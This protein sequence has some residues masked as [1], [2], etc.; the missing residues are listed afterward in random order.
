MISHKYPFN[1]GGDSLAE[2][3]FKET[4]R[5]AGPA[6]P[7]HLE[8]RRKRVAQFLSTFVTKVNRQERGLKPGSAHTAR[9]ASVFTE[10][11]VFRPPPP[12][13][14]QTDGPDCMAW[15]SDDAKIPDQFRTRRDQPGGLTG[16]AGFP[17]SPRPFRPPLDPTGERL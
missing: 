17:S 1:G 12:E 14:A 3:A 8:T 15:V 7:G 13:Y 4:G 2:T 11:R 6:N 16:T 5:A 10:N 9:A